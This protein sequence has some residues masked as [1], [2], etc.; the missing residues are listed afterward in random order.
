MAALI[1]A[2]A[3][4]FGA[5]AP[6]QEAPPRLSAGNWTPPLPEWRPA[7]PQPSPVPLGA[8]P[9]PPPAAWE[10]ALR[11]RPALVPVA[12]APAGRQGPELA[13]LGKWQVEGG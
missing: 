5:P 12:L 6:A 7:T 9:V 8:T 11:R 4:W 13:E 3:L 10:P 2:L 1:S